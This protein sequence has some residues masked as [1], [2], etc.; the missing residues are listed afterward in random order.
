MKYRVDSVNTDA[1]IYL[2]YGSNQTPPHVT[3]WQ[4]L[5]GVVNSL[6]ERGVETLKISR[7]WES[8]A[9]PDPTD[10]RYYN[11]VLQIDTDIDPQLLLEVLHNLEAQ[12]GR[13][14][15]FTDNKR[16]YAPRVLDLDLICY[17]RRILRPEG[18]L[19][20]TQAPAL[21]LPHPRAAER[22]F[23]MGPLSEIAPDWVH[24]VLG[25]TARDLWSEVTVGRD[26]H[27]INEP[28][29]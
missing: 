19:A 21:A 12:M 7:L 8:L 9:W 22:G 23:V 16:R 6:R 5:A 3:P 15:D 10:P 18:D 24:P 25:R 29:A 2:S 26:A 28:A 20:G 27:P 17:G 1:A 13:M 14:R 4:A 11:A